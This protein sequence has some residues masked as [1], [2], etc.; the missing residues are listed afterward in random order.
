MFSAVK[1]AIIW[2]RLSNSRSCQGLI[3]QSIIRH[4]VKAIHDECLHIAKGMDCPPKMT[5]MVH[6]GILRSPTRCIQISS[7]STIFKVSTTYGFFLGPN[8]KA[9]EHACFLPGGKKVRPV[10]KKSTLQDE[11]CTS[12][13]VE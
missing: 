12:K 1:L 13:D 5:P 7:Q 10:W 4:S 6:Q 11:Q 2:I 8:C 3:F 9:P